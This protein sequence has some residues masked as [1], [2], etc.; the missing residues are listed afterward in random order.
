MRFRF[1]SALVVAGVALLVPATAFAGGA[2]R[3]SLPVT[4]DPYYGFHVGVPSGWNLGRLNGM[5]VVNKDGA[6][7]VE[8]VVEPVVL[9]R[10]LTS[11]T[12]SRAPPR[13]S[14]KRW[15]RGEARSRSA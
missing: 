10:G 15:R 11:G 7:T 1:W 13:R 12:S 5:I 4:H 3:C 9:T 14:G 2:A 6:G 8:A